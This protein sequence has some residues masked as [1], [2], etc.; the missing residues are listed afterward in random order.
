ME[1]EAEKNL[2]IL[3]VRL[4]YLRERMAAAEPHPSSYNIREARALEFVL[5][6]A[7]GG[8]DMQE[9]K[10]FSDKA[11]KVKELQ[12]RY[13]LD[14]EG[15][16]EQMQ[17]TFGK[18][19]G[20]LLQALGLLTSFEWEPA[21]EYTSMWSDLNPG[22]L[23]EGILPKIG[24]VQ[25]FGRQKSYKSEAALDLA[26]RVVNKEDSDWCG[27]KVNYHGAVCYVLMEGKATF[28]QRI[29]AWENANPGTNEEQLFLISQAPLQL[30]DKSSVQ[31][32]AMGVPLSGKM[33]MGQESPIDVR[34][35]VV[36]TQGMATVGADENSFRDM[37]LVLSNARWLAEEFEALVLLV[38]HTGWGKATA[39]RG[40]GSS[41]LAAGLDAS[42]ECK[43]TP[44]G[45]MLRPSDIKDA[46]T[47]SEW[48]SYRIER[49]NVEAGSGKY[50]ETISCIYPVPD[51]R[52]G[53]DDYLKAE[54][55]LEAAGEVGLSR[56]ALADAIAGNHKPLS[57]KRAD[58]VIEGFRGE[59]RLEDVEGKKI[60]LKVLDA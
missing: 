59:G 11:A 21:E 24:V 7:R 31:A 39:D 32:L 35:F 1:Q 44:A 16:H 34:L 15:F 22:W 29:V 43:R 2:R 57:M 37:S 26:I 53:D 54:A 50:S 48:F 47:A 5:D 51:R 40:R 9:L 55:A 3:E 27:H 28:W 36:D 20:Q 38:H 14:P 8:V 12:A 58:T 46:G 19:S 6:L 45:Y 23:V 18:E 25:L 4:D 49:I 56:T 41:A 42:V 13:G 33:F 60:A 17:K 10:Y 52:G 30:Q